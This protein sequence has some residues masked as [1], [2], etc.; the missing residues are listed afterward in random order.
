MPAFDNK[1]LYEELKKLEFI[2]A[3]KLDAAFAQSQ[4]TNTPLYKTLL[5]KELITDKDLGIILAD[6]YG[7]PFLSLAQTTIP[8]E[9]LAIIPQ[10][11]AKKQ[12]AIAVSQDQNGL[13][14]ATT[15]PQNK[16]FFDLLFKKTGLK[17]TPVY[18]TEAEIENAMG[19]YQ[20]ELQTTFD[21]I[22]DDA[23]KKAANSTSVEAPIANIVD[24]LVKYA[25]SNKASDIHIEPYDSDS[26]IRFR[27]DGVLHDVLRLP[28]NLHDQ[29]IA[30]IK[31]MAKLRTDEHLKAQDGKMQA[32]LENED[33]DIRVSIVPIVEGEKAVLRLLSSHYRQFAL[34]ELGLTD[35]NIE[36]VKSGFS[37]PYGMVLATGPTGSGKTTTI[38]AILKIINT[39]DKNIS[40]IEDPVEY[41]IEGVNQIQVNAKTDLTFANGLRSIV[42]QDPD[43]IFVGEI[44]DNETAGIAINSAMTGHLVLSTI[45]TNNAATTLPR[46]IDMDI[47]PF[48]VAS[49]V[50]VIVA[51]RLVRKICQ[52]CRVSQNI[53]TAELLKLLPKDLVEKHFVPSTKEGKESSTRTYIGKG[54]D[55]C[56]KTGY[57]G[58]IGI[59]E[60]MVVSN[61]IKDLITKKSDSNIIE[62]KAREEGMVSMLE[63]GIEKVKNGITTL[64]EIIRSTKE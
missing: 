56:H 63:D 20:K 54:C 7:V 11:V 30:R 58:R 1:R 27:I 44:R 19:L 64:E 52:K 31:V 13:K 17:I 61:S 39:R 28:K 51:Q 36:K 60:V 4:K 42:R 10:I 62:S 57:S 59:F 50:N 48:L 32:K 34:P 12:Q 49:T 24:L 16:E 47:E 23:V 37:K 9:T 43:I 21:K 40:T 2:D 41:D 26:L 14:I 33:L 38:Y 53:T 25:S 15:N 6:L 8:K 22:L 45:H 46:L 18:S 5:S 3:K 35:E 29:I 55:V